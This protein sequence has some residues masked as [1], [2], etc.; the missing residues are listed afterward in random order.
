MFAQCLAIFLCKSCGWGIAIDYCFGFSGNMNQPCFCPKTKKQNKTKHTLK[1]TISSACQSCS[2]GPGWSCSFSP[3]KAMVRRLIALSLSP[4]K[5]ILKM[6]C[7]S[8]VLHQNKDSQFTVC[9][10]P[11]ICMNTF[12]QQI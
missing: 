1:E 8:N 2:Q 11:L 12:L 5:S 9:L 7:S 4:S 6:I 3:W 10:I